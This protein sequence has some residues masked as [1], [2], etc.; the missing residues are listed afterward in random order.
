MSRSDDF[1]GVLE[2]VTNYIQN[3]RIAS[4]NEGAA[5]MIDAIKKW[6]NIHGPAPLHDT[7][8]ELLD[9]IVAARDK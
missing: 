2:G 6:M 1:V 9:Q 4:Y 8:P 7:V 5:D 3:E